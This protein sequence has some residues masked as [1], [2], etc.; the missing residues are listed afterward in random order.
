MRRNRMLIYNTRVR[1]SK[2]NL[3]KTNEYRH[4]CSEAVGVL[5]A[6]ADSCRYTFKKGSNRPC[7][8][9]HS[10]EILQLN[11]ATQLAVSRKAGAAR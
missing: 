3:G 1:Q 2:A 9:L 8:H 10:R 6:V 11:V 7:T 4:H 5:S